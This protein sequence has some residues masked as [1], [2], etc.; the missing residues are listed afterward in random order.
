MVTR[1][2]S[3]KDLWGSLKELSGFVLNSVNGAGITLQYQTDKNTDNSWND[4]GNAGQDYASLF[5][6]EDT[7]D[8][9]RIRFRIKG[10]TSGPS[11]IIDGIEVQSLLDKGFKNN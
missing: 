10:T 11:I 3:I 5:P 2:I 8:F 4:I 9:D 6:N 7:L 1:W